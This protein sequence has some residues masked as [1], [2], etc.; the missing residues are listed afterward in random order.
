MS[1]E[2]AIP[3]VGFPWGTF[4]AVVVIGAFSLLSLYLGFEAIASGRT[5]DANYYLILGST[6]FAAM[7]Y[8]IF[9]SR[10]TTVRK[11]PIPRV[12]VVATLECPA[13]GFKKVRGFKKGDYVF[14]EDEPCTHCQ[15]RMVIIR[16]HKR[17]KKR[18][19]RRW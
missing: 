13:C 7:G 10:V 6:G 8:M 15:G 4:I 14:K 18:K 3:S 11:P 1:G 2:S 19:I 9:R 16:I 17:E 12:E 5:E